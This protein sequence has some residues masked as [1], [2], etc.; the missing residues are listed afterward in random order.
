MK[1]VLK[2]QTGKYA[3]IVLENGTPQLIGRSVVTKIKNSRCSKK[4]G[5]TGG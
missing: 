4:Q 2:S 3:D 5:K 1:C